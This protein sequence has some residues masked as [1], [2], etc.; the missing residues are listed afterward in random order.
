LKIIKQYIDENTWS[1]T[2]FEK[3]IELTEG[4]GYWKKNTVEQMLK[5]GMVVHTPFARFKLDAMPVRL[6]D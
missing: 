3:A 5:K 1:P 6:E 4:C 2:T